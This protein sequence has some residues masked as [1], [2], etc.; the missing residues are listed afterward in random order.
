MSNNNNN[1][2]NFSYYP[3]QKIKIMGIPSCE[4]CTKARQICLE[5]NLQFEWVDCQ[6]NIQAKKLV[7]SSG[8]NF[9]LPMIFVNELFLGSLKEF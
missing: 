3:Q 2:V 8:K 9:P 5:Y 6:V 7:E 1:S 4:K